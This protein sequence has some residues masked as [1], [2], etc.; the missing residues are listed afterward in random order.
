MPSHITMP[1]EAFT[2]VITLELGI[3]AALVF[4]MIVQ[5]AFTFIVTT[6]FFRTSDPSVGARFF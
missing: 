4:E 2:A 5:T 1:G 3:D 6:A